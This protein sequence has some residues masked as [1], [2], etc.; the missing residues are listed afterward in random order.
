MLKKILL[1]IL[2]LSSF[3]ASSQSYTS[4]A[5]AAQDINE[6][7]ETF[8]ARGT[9]TISSYLSN[10][11]NDNHLYL[12]SYFKKDRTTV[13]GKTYRNMK[14]KITLIMKNANYVY[15]DGNK[16]YFDLNSKGY[17]MNIKAPGESWIG[18][19]RYTNDFTITITNSSDRKK[20]LK[21]FKYLIKHP[22]YYK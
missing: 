20:A 13:K 22:I 9:H 4:Q 2:I 5:Q 8:G 17:N 15:E 10:D 3:I 12:Y 18:N 16:L 1:S 14:F 7:I 6:I 11:P 21:A 19:R